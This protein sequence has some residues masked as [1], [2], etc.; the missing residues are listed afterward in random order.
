MRDLS[1][2]EVLSLTDLLKL[3][4]D[5][6]TVAKALQSL[7]K[8]DELKKTG[9][10]NILAAEGRIKGIRQFVIENKVAD[11]REVQ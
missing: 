8:N 6:L 10:A 11:I 1:E 4:Q 3:E 7:I 9:E 2:A 5:G